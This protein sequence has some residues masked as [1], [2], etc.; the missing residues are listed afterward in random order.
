MDLKVGCNDVLIRDTPSGYKDLVI[1]HHFAGEMMH[2]LPGLNDWFNTYFAVTDKLQPSSSSSSSSVPE[3]LSNST[4][5]PM[6][7]SSDASG[8]HSSSLSQLPADERLLY[9]SSLVLF[10][11]WLCLIMLLLMLCVLLQSTRSLVPFPLQF[12]ITEIFSRL[13]TEI[14]FTDYH[15]H[16]QALINWLFQENFPFKYFFSELLKYFNVEL[17]NANQIIFII[18]DSCSVKR[19]SFSFHLSQRERRW[20]HNNWW[21]WWWHGW[22]LSWRI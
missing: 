15:K 12:S 2:W 22:W 4:T 18:S 1:I 17:L 7:L 3:K 5:S 10:F 21:C 16:N 9:L 19:L 13:T 6:S 20:R 14:F 8:G 11:T